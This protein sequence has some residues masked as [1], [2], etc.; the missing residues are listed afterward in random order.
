M[1]WMTPRE[2]N[3]HL[4]GP[5]LAKRAG[6]AGDITLKDGKIYSA[7][8]LADAGLSGRH[9][10]RMYAAHWLDMA[11]TDATPEPLDR[12]GDGKPGGSLTDEEQIALAELGYTLDDF[13][14]LPDD[15]RPDILAKAMAGPQPL[16]PVSE[17]EA[18]III[19]IEADGVSTTYVLTAPGIEPERFDDPAAAD[20]RQSELRAQARQAA[21]EA[22]TSGEGSDTPPNEEKAPDGP[23]NGTDGDLQPKAEGATAAAAQGEAGAAEVQGDA[24]TAP[25][26]TVIAGYRHFGFGAYF[27][28][29]AA[30][31]K[32]GDKMAKTAAQGFAAR[33]NVPLLSQNDELP[34]S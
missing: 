33:D 28:I 1:S 29:N 21:Q 13:L 27:A 18:A 10:Q 6:G 5:F 8:Q 20:A 16:E 11:P 4:A 2:A 34:Q 23:E 30:G 19:S 3:F 31:Q 12:D 7:K 32:L 22:L 9:I 17:A 14:A 15:Q 26:D 24:A 25:A